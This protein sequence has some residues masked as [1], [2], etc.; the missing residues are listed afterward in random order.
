MKMVQVCRMRSDQELDNF[1]KRVSLQVGLRTCSAVGR[2]RCEVGDHWNTNIYSFGRWA[3]PPSPHIQSSYCTRPPLSAPSLSSLWTSNMIFSLSFAP[4]AFFIMHTSSSSSSSSWMCCFP[5]FGSCTLHTASTSKL[6]SQ[7]A[8]NMNQNQKWNHP[9]T[10]FSMFVVP[11]INEKVRK[12]FL[13]LCFSSQ[14]FCFYLCFCDFLYLFH[15]SLLCCL[16]VALCG[17]FVLFCFLFWLLLCFILLF[18]LV[19]LSSLLHFVVILTLLWF[20]LRSLR[21]LFWLFVSLWLFCCFIIFLY[22]H[23]FVVFCCLSY[24]SLSVVLEFFVSL[25]VFFYGFSLYSII[26]ATL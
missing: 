1:T 11:R 21:V 19:S 6:W 22:F 20:C 9:F 14:S 4:S 2:P 26:L 8:T 23:L 17:Y 5:G 24:L 10:F 25:C 3:W 16:F 12:A 7:R 13:L 15:F 18:C